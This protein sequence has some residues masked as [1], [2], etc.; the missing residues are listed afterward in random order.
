MTYTILMLTKQSLTLSYPRTY[1]TCLT[2]QR[3][4]KCVTLTLSLTAVGPFDHTVF[5]ME[6]ALKV[7]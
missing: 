5:L 2:N 7:F 6:K 3:S 1:S 4:M